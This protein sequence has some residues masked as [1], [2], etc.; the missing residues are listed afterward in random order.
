MPG[1]SNPLR[2]LIDGHAHL[3][4]IDDIEGALERAAAASVARI[5]AVGM[6]IASNRRVL[7]LAA[8]YP[9]FVLPAVGFHPWSIPTGP[10]EATVAF[11]R[12]HLESCTPRWSVSSSKPTARSNTG[13]RCPNRP[14]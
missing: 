2:E 12:T 5:V 14:T 10:I 3:N 6:D 9:G 4:E 7:E 13:G 11:V 1:Q 8:A